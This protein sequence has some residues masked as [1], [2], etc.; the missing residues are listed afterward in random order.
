MG[1]RH[2]LFLVTLLAWC[3][4]AHATTSQYNDRTSWLNATSGVINHDFNSVA[5]G[6]YSTAGGLIDGSV[7]F[8]GYD[9][10]NSSFDLNVVN[11]N[12]WN[13]GQFLE[14]PAPLSP[15]SRIEV[16]LPS[17]IFAV[18][19]DI[20]Y[21]SGNS[22]G[23]AATMNIRLSTG[24]TYSATTVAGPSRQRVL[25]MSISAAVGSGGICH[26]D[27]D[28]TNRMSTIKIVGSARLAN[29]FSRDQPLAIPDLRVRSSRW[30]RLR[31]GDPPNGRS[32][33]RFRRSSRRAYRAVAFR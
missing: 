16:T 3:V 1:F 12:Y 9:Q 32:R 7:N 8:V 15:N 4:A 19:S 30:G 24:S 33:V 6:G 5:P 14:G 28:D 2:L 10:L 27:Y 29:A 26:R 11:A 31:R 21:G 18:G 25:R 20:M 22:S 17:A 13:S 23:S